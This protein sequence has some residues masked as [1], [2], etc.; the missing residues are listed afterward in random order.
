MRNQISIAVEIDILQQLEARCAESG[1]SRSE[2][3]NRALAAYL[4][5]PAPEKGTPGP[6]AGGKLNS[7]QRLIMAILEKNEDGWLPENEIRHTTGISRGATR[8]ALMELQLMGRVADL[9]MVDNPRA[10]GAIGE[11]V[12]VRQWAYIVPKEQRAA[13]LGTKG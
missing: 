6:K 1:A 13:V 12:K 3:V 11:L 2:L 4:G 9:G 5:V 10:S 8:R 7:T